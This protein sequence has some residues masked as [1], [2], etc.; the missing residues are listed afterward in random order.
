MGGERDIG[1]QIDTAWKPGGEIGH[2]W[3]WDPAIIQ[4]EL[5][6]S[7][8]GAQRANIAVRTEFANFAV[9]ISIRTGKEGSTPY[10]SLA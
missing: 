5:Q 3:E 1:H 7:K 9:K 6:T 8:G 10:R 2:D 4:T